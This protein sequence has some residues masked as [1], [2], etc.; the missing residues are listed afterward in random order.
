[1]KLA[2]L[3]ALVVAVLAPAPAVAYGCA[4]LPRIAPPGAVL[5]WYSTGPCAESWVAVSVT[6]LA[7]DR[8]ASDGAVIAALTV[9]L[10]TG[11]APMP[12][13][14]LGAPQPVV[15][16]PDGLG[17]VRSQTRLV[18]H[19]GATAALARADGV[20]ILDAVPF[21]SLCVEGADPD[22]CAG[23]PKTAPAWAI[24]KPQRLVLVFPTPPSG[25][26]RAQLRIGWIAHSFDN[27]GI[28]SR[29]RG[30]GQPVVAFATITVPR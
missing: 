3:V 30:W 22:P 12:A 21:T 20:A 17:V 29:P 14:P 5:P 4:S 19:G 6:D 11:Q 13:T 26:A 16:V 15:V 1:M 24:G 10:H 28:Y 8:Q 25:V 18:Y 2:G 9:I 27:N 23:L 7:V